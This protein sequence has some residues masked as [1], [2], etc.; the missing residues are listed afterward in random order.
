MAI[1]VGLLAGAGAILLRRLI[2]LAR[3]LFQ[4]LPGRIVPDSIVTSFVPEPHMV[5]APVIGFL[6]V[7]VWIARRS[8]ESRGSGVPEAQHAVRAKGG[9]LPPATAFWE[10]LASAI[11]IGSGG[12]VGREGPIVL[13][14]SSLGSSV[15]QALGLG[16]NELRLLLA[17]GAAGAVGATFNA[18]IA[19][20]MFA[21]EVILASFAGRAFGLVVIASVSATALSRAFLGDSPAFTLVEGF[22]LVSEW[23]FGL[24]LVLGLVAGGAAVLYIRMVDGGAV[25]FERWDAGPVRKAVSGGLGVGVLGTVGFLVAGPVMFDVGNRGV[26]LALAGELAVAGMILLV[27]LKMAATSLTLAAG[28][29]GGVFAPALFIGSMLGASFGVLAN[30][31]F[32]GW[33]A[34]AGAYALVGMAALFGAAAH[35][36]ITAIVILFEMTDE[37]RIMLPLMFCV[38]VA[39]LVA[40]RISEDSIYS[41][42]LRRRGPME[43]EGRGWS[44]LDM[45]LVVDTM[46]E[47]VETIRPDAT[48]HELEELARHRR[49]RSW[50]V[51][52]D[53]KALEG[54]VT[55]TDLERALLG[56]PDEST[57]VAD[58]MTRSVITCL[59]GDT[60]RTAFRRFAE[61]DVQLIPVLEDGELAGVLRRHDM[62]WA[63]REMSHEHEALLDRASLRVPLDRDET[64]QVE[65]PVPPENRAV[66]YRRVREVRVP[67]HT[68]IV[69]LRRG[70]QAMV[71][72]GD[73]RIEPGDTLVLLTT[74][75]F[76]G[77][78]H[79]WLARG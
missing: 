76:E 7:G 28:G 2:E 48:L 74:R 24:Y 51:S 61:R 35:A 47:E 75:R 45:I 33:T 38:V 5:I 66:A 79:D 31:L 8:P 13:I 52:P 21:L 17:C 4:E 64:V 67:P 30:Y 37:Y 42:K 25:L 9:R 68:L 65:Y 43:E 18:P 54:I 19:G 69:L 23:E 20:V 72:R 14:G 71:P 57:R 58:I 11:T 6:V 10:A 62:L 16:R 3:W 63:Y 73:T 26:E 70:G 60:I 1:L 15:G 40:S 44:V 41:I 39:Y 77:E 55:E 53:G 36:P 46:D 22:S 34:P 27:L 49:T 12:S 32:P 78:I 29:S 50:P 56:V 59:P